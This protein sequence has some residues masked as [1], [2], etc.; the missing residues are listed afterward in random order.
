MKGCLERGKEYLW[1]I[2][3]YNILSKFRG[4][5][6]CFAFLTEISESDT[7]SISFCIISAEIRNKMEM[8][9]QMAARW[10]VESKQPLSRELVGINIKS[11]YSVSLAAQTK[12]WRHEKR[13]CV[14]IKQKRIGELHW[15]SECVIKCAD[16]CAL[17]SS[18]NCNINSA[19]HHLQAAQAHK[20]YT[21]QLTCKIQLDEINTCYKK[22]IWQQNQI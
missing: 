11:K 4:L 20:V 22:V 8:R 5:E 19:R 10:Q 1:N 21:Q 2:R 16:K 12:P 7:N 15:M 3:Q 6:G 9:I 13:R 18:N 17:A 14:S